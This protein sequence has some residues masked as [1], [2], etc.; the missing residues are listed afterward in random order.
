MQD[1]LKILLEDKVNNLLSDM[2]DKL[3]VQDSS[4][5]N[6]TY[7]TV[8]GM[9]L[10]AIITVTSQYL[11]IRKTI[12]ADFEKIRLQ[13]HSDFDF[14][15]RYEWVSNFRQIISEL[16]TT[17]DPD[18]NKELNKTKMLLLINQA[19]IML[20]DDIKEEKELEGLITK[21]GMDADYLKSDTKESDKSILQTQDAILKRT[22]QLLNK[23]QFENK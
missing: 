19:Q 7:V 15:N 2:V 17:T 18:Y 16:I 20:S 9:L 5:L 12:K 6:S 11:L 3:S 23:K 22:K 8:I 13:I 4:N 14:K 10:V 1:T 21:L